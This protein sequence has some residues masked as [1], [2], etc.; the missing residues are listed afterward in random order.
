MTQRFFTLIVFFTINFIV[1]AQNFDKNQTSFDWE[2]RTKSNQIV[3][4]EL[5]LYKTPSDVIFTI[6]GQEGYFKITLDSIEKAEKYGKEIKS[7]EF[8]SFLSKF[9][10]KSQTGITLQIIGGLGSIILP[11]ADVPLAVLAVPPVVTV[12]GFVIWVSSYK[13]LK[14]Y[15]IIQQAKYYQ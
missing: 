1:F 12:T 3:Y 15:T 13:A 11:L 7:T 5:V 6:E 10:N 2:I 14:Q 4:A 8:T 9:V